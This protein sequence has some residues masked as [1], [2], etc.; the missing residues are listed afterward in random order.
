MPIAI[1]QRFPVGV[2]MGQQHYRAFVEGAEAQDER[3]M[4]ADVWSALSECT[5]RELEAVGREQVLRELLDDAHRRIRTLEAT[6]ERL[7]KQELVEGTDVDPSEDPA[8]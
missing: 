2:P 1:T 5:Q 3:E 4:R 6:L 8:D 7:T